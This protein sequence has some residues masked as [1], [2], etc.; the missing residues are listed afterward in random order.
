[1][2]KSNIEKIME[3]ILKEESGNSQFTS[4]ID[5]INVHVYHLNEWKKYRETF[6]EKEPDDYD[7]KPFTV[8]WNFQMEM[9]NDGIYGMSTSIEG[10]EGEIEIL[11][12]NE[13]SDDQEG[14]ET[15]AFDDT[16]LESMKIVNTLVPGKHNQVFI[17]GI[18]ID[19]RNNEV[20]IEYF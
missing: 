2:T 13:Q 12:Y 1:M 20:T 16:D 19:F 18:S 10:I 9:K 17:N 6:G 7:T 15:I 5:S 14:S 8:N 3:T 11:T 4:E